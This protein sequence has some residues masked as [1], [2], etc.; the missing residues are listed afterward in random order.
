MSD[1]M[2]FEEAKKFGMLNLNPRLRKKFEKNEFVSLCHEIGCVWYYQIR[3]LLSLII[4]CDYQKKYNIMHDWSAVQVLDTFAHH[5]HKF[6]TQYNIGVSFLTRSG[7]V[8]FNSNAKQ[9][10]DRFGLHNYKLRMHYPE[11]RRTHLIEELKADIDELF[12][13]NLLRALDN[14]GELLG[15]TFGSG[16]L[17]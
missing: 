15:Q 5:A 17:T 7:E 12:S 1:F 3:Y 13:T 2:S 6:S 9:I 8:R 11:T 10:L 14:E 16:L 4:E